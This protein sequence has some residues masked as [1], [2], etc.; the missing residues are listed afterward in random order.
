MSYDSVTG[1]LASRRR[2]LRSATMSAWGSTASRP[3][4]D[5]LVDTGLCKRHIGYR[6]VRD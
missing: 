6:L 3:D 2:H 5:Q 1:L 4:A